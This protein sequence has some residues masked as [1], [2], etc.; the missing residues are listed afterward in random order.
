MIGSLLVVFD[1]RSNGINPN[2]REAE[3]T[4]TCSLPKSARNARIREGRLVKST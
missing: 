2:T 4:A 1:E 3:K